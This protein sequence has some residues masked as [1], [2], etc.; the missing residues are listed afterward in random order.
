MDTQ[1]LMKQLM[2]LL[3]GVTEPE[4]GQEI[5]LP[6]LR[7][8]GEGIP[9][10]VLIGMAETLF[11]EILEERKRTQHVEQTE[12]EQEPAEPVIEPITEPACDQENISETI[13]HV[14]PEPDIPATELDIQTTDPMMETVFYPVPEKEAVA[15]TVAPTLSPI[16][17]PEPPRD[18]LISDKELSAQETLP[19]MKA[20]SILNEVEPQPDI[21]R[22]APLAQELVPAQNSV[23]TPVSVPEAGVAPIPERGTEILDERAFPRWIVDWGGSLPM[24]GAL[25]SPKFLILS[26]WFRS[27]PRI[28]MVL[29]ERLT[30]PYWNRTPALSLETEGAW[31]Y[32]EQLNINI[33]ETFTAGREYLLRVRAVFHENEGR[34]VHCFQGTMRIKAPDQSQ[35]QRTLEISGE[36]ASLINLSSADLAEFQ[37]VHITGGDQTLINVQRGWTPTDAGKNEPRHHLVEMQLRPDTVAQMIVPGKSPIPI[38]PFRSEKIVFSSESGE[39]SFFIFAKP[40]IRIGRSAEETLTEEACDIVTRLYHPKFE[41]VDYFDENL[42]AASRFLTRLFSRNHCEINVQPRGLRIADTNSTL[43]T[44]VADQPV[45]NSQVL[46]EWKHLQRGLSIVIGGL[47]ELKVKTHIDPTWNRIGSLNVFRNEELE[48]FF[49]QV[50]FGDSLSFHAQGMSG[51]WKLAAEQGFCDALVISRQKQLVFEKYRDAVSERIRACTDK[52]E[53]ILTEMDKSLHHCTYDPFAKSRDYIMLFRS[54]TIGSG[55]EDAI[56]MP[57]SGLGEGIARVLSINKMFWIEPLQVDYHPI[58]INEQLLKRNEL[59]PLAPNQTISFGDKKFIVS[60]FEDTPTPKFRAG[61]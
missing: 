1:A 43:G 13:S 35:T 38:T 36:G 19:S 26:P 2:I 39:Q 42:I 9:D 32:Y 44:F 21:T 59:C 48:V 24:S 16:S 60:S 34:D 37:R 15:E 10:E 30:C 51:L 20:V 5:I 11:Q 23:P 54:A 40:D 49:T 18:E 56:C 53:T 31:S 3:D 7:E 29:D 25:L 33:D 17:S 6:I 14:E 27:K 45:L 22:P 55:R 46:A 12:L 57:N 61:F 28:Q 4:V 58:R 50:A 52:A 41:E 8:I 47:L